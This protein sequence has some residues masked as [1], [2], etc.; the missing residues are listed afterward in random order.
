[1]KFIDLHADTLMHTSLTGVDS[2]M[3]N[4]QTHLDIQRLSQGGAMAQ[5]LAV[6]M[7]NEAIIKK[8]NRPIISDKEYIDQLYNHLQESI[9][10]Y[11]NSIQLATNYETL[12]SNQMANNI[13]IFLTLEDGRPIG[14]DLTRLENLYEMGFRLVTL[15][16]NKE[17]SI[18]YP[19]S[20]DKNDMRKGLKKFGFEVIELMNSLGMVIDV[21]HLS[22]GGFYDVI[23]TSNKPIIASHSN[24]RAI[25]SHPRNLSDD[26]IKKIA[27]SGGVIGLNFLGNFL[28]KDITQNQ[29]TIKVMIEHLN[30]IRNIGGAEVLA[31]GTDFDGMSGELEIDGPDKMN[32]LFDALW[33]SG[34]DYGTI[35]KFGF[36]NAMR[37]IKDVMK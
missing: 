14:E 23:E 25:S 33:H 4:S 1:M 32:L 31:L 7:L 8:Q 24:A 27:E 9:E 35:E 11:N 22:D 17:N 36:Q 37:V 5:F 16:W 18:G 34:W 20:F 3:H 12:E 30:H 29:S 26:M 2:L 21:S 10:K 13:S 15:T 6:F 19:N 28:N